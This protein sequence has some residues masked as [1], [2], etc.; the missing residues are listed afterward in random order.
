MPTELDRACEERVA[1]G[2][3]EPLD[4]T[5]TTKRI[6]GSA[7]SVTLPG[8]MAA[9]VD[10]ADLRIAV[11]P[12]RGANGSIERLRRVVERKVQK[13]AE[14]SSPRLS[15]LRGYGAAAEWGV[16][17][18]ADLA[19]YGRNE[20]PWSFCDP[21]ALLTGPPGTGKTLFAAAIAREAETAFLAGSLAQWQ[22]DGEAHL[23]TT[24]K[25]MRGFFREA[26]GMAPC[27]AL[28][29]EL[30]SFG[31]RR[32]LADQNR[33]YS[34]QVINGFL[35][36]LDGD[37]G[38][39][40]VLLIGTTNDSDRIDP[41]ILRSGRFDRVIA[42]EPP[43]LDDLAGILRHHL[44]SDLP[45]VDLPEIARR[46]LGGT[47]ADCAAWVRRA[48]GRAR[49]AG[50]AVVEADL[51]LEIASPIREN[52]A[53]EQRRAAFHEAGHAV[54]AR[55]LG[56]KHGDLVLCSPAHGGDGYMRCGLPRVMTRRTLQD[57]LVMLLAGRAAEILVFGLPSSGA[58]TD[59]AVATGLARAMHLRW[60]LAERLAVGDTLEG[61]DERDRIE[62]VLRA[63]A[64]SALRLLSIRRSS[65]DR[66]ARAL[67]A[68][69]SLTAAELDRIFGGD[70]CGQ[71]G[72]PCSGG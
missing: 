33:N 68:R 42:I 46:G 20:I 59:L 52:C 11:H 7:P 37:G 38:R 64:R 25:A 47:G 65:L 70:G 6:V 43:S 58:E 16:A 55:S 54:A 19:A 23:G 18:A 32:R 41:A 12:A 28:V 69:R 10:P 51:L 40:G 15:E 72:E 56:L 24:L 29:D 3:L 48:R 36:C 53:E 2:P 45:D 39:A 21:G 63:A 27:V 34:V 35:E 26:R 60:G 57:T 5:L 4:L 17:A 9:H 50:R 22:A 13:P 66:V 14:N 49:R 44:G 8:E 61:S 71:A 67:L 62:R 30:D 1:L 31:D